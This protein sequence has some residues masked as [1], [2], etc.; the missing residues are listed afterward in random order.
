MGQKVNP[1]GFRVSHFKPWKSRWFDDTDNFKE[2]LVEDIK[3]RRML[4]DR[5]AHAGIVSVDIERLAKSIVINLTVSR[6]GVVIG[7]GGSGIE[8]TKKEVVD[9]I[10]KIRGKKPV[11]IKIDMPVHE[12]K[13]PET[14]AQLVASRIAQDMERRMRHRVVVSKAMDRVMNAGAKG[15]KVVVSGRIGG[16][17]IA[18]VEKFKKGSVPAQT[19]RA[20]IDYASLPANLK[21]GK[22]GIKVYIHKKDDED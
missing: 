3:I 5:L 19:M 9:L 13:D 15:I 14:S 17:E 22:V 20:N 2:Y 12:V 18:R 16:S 4:M 6:P 1:T 10:T 21:R 11:D 7:R 8:E